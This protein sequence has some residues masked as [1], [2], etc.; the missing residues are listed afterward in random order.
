MSEFRSESV[1]KSQAQIQI[2]ITN[3]KPA[4]TLLFI[5]N[6]LYVDAHKVSIL[7]Q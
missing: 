7:F 5:L 6:E 2:A 1:F 3:M 4:E